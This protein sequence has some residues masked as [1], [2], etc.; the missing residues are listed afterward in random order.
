LLLCTSKHN[1]E[2]KGPKNIKYVDPSKQ[3]GENFDLKVNE[4]GKIKVFTLSFLNNNNNNNNNK[5]FVKLQR[6]TGNKKGWNKFG[7]QR[8][9]RKKGQSRK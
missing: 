2:T 9:A 4:K 5:S 3:E 7:G 6:G 1:I 8:G